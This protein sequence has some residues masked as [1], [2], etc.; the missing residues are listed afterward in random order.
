MTRRRCLVFSE[1][2]TFPVRVVRF[3]CSDSN[4]KY[5]SQTG[6]DSFESFAFDADVTFDVLIGLCVTIP[7]FIVSDV[8]APR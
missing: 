5:S 7:L 4:I 6:S 8:V 2:D 3:S 1:T